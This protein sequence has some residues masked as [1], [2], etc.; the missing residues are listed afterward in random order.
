MHQ[1]SRS[2]ILS[3]DGAD[4]GYVVGLKPCT[5]GSR[6]LKVSTVYFFKFENAGQ[7]FRKLIIL[8]YGAQLQNTMA[9]QITRIH[10]LIIVHCCLYR[11][12]FK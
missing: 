11:S 4:P 1:A 12:F 6:K 8:I 2:P 5:Q 7:N 10:L 9:R 3:Q